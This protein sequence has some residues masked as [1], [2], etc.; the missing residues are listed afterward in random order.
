MNGKKRIL[1]VD[2]EP[3]FTR[4]LR[5]N[6]HWLGRY[7]VEVV[8][9]PTEALEVARQFRPNLVLMDV[10]M[11]SMDGG[12]LAAVFGADPLFK[13]TPIVFLTAAIDP[14]E[15]VSRRGKIGG[16]SFVSKPVEVQEVVAAIEQHFQ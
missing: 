1:L 9:D 13:E 3:A 8:N 15:V 5:L 2:D 6:L 14:G 16:L 12:E 4:L 7:T 11:P 10:M